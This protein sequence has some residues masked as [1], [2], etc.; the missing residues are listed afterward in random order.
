MTPIQINGVALTIEDVDTIERLSLRAL[1]QAVQDF[2][3]D[4]WQIFHQ[5]TDD[6]KDVAEDCTREMLDRFGGYGIIQRIYGNVDYRKARHIILPDYSIRQAL[7]VDSKAEKTNATATLQMSQISMRVRQ[8][9]DGQAIDLPGRLQCI[10]RYSGFEYLSTTLL[11]HYCYSSPNQSQ[12][13]DVPPYNLKQI[14]LAA[15]PNGLLQS[16]YNPDE[17]T[18]FW[19]AGRN[20]PSLGEEFRVR[21]NFDDLQRHSK[22]RVQTVTY[23]D[24]QERIIGQWDT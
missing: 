11:V 15:I 24:Q 9:R 19:R 3:F 22:W 16:R 6:P 21:L 8:I 14:K 7:F 12:G 5:S 4:A 1:W 18:G 20:A 10:E 2:G 17:N 23:D 13:R